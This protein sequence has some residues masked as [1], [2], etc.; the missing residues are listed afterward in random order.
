MRRLAACV[1]LIILVLPL[2][3]G[4]VAQA[5][6]PPPSVLRI[7]LS[8]LPKS[9]FPI[10]P[11]TREMSY[12]RGFTGRSLTIYD[13]SWAV[14]CALCTELPSLQNG[15]VRIV[16]RADGRKG[17][18]VT[19]D[20]LPDLAW[21][22]GAPVT[23]EDVRLGVD[24]AHALGSGAAALPN[25]LDVVVEGDR[26][27]TLRT[28]EMRFDYNRMEELLLLPAHRERAAF[29][30][31]ATPA[32]YRAR[33]LYTTD[34]TAP[35]LSYGPYRLVRT[36]P[37][38][39][40]LARNPHWH[41]KQ[42]S[43]ERIELHEVADPAVL[44][45][46]LRAH[47]IDMVAGETALDL[48]DIYRLEAADRNS[49]YEF[50]YKP[51]LEYAHIDVNLS[52]ELLRDK[53][54]RRAL[55]LSLDRPIQIS[56]RDRQ[57]RGEAPPSFLP[58]ASP[59]FDPTLKPAPYDPAQAAAVLDAAGFAMGPDGIRADGQGRR[60]AFG[61]AAELDFPFSR[62]LAETVREQWRRSGI[63]ITLEDR[64]MAEILPKRQF[65][66]AYYAWVNAPEFLL[67]PVY[68][69]TGIPSAENN[70][71]GLNFPGLDNAEMNQVTRALTTE[72][73]PGKRLLLWRR[74]QQIYAEELPALPL[75]F[76][77]Q[78]FILPTGMTGV[79]P[80]GHLI[81]TSYWVEDWKIE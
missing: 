4:P 43:F 36:A 17:I 42:P 68:G 70:F 60:L 64:R 25:V 8:S 22:D 33:S 66:L 78:K 29:D 13:K 5:S 38:E 73:D 34:P 79:E 50:I 24:V 28:A 18:D 1:G 74:A 62:R 71:R 41:G 56:G 2:L 39:L 30:A 10:G 72:M 23:T 59:N 32:E 48:D 26:R 19:F 63:E 14:A 27:F 58:P 3:Q 53:R 80:T 55:L 46:D 7:A 57:T 52:N 21:D 75:A 35:G 54:I 65:D 37:D 81:P 11:R 40:A 47:R 20:L 77:P 12:L 51:Q 49:A 9:L 76:V 67:A 45:A 44:E 6:D 15:R 61:L 16:Q 31:A 69:A